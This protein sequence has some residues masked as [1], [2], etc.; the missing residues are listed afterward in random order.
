MEGTRD[1]HGIVFESVCFTYDSADGG[2]E[3]VAGVDL[4]VA[5]GEMTAVVGRNGS[6][7]STLALLANGLLHPSE[8]AVRVDGMYTTEQEHTWDIRSRV[9]IVFQN[10]DNQIVGTIVEE[11]VAFGP[12]NLGVSRPELRFRVDSALEI[13]GLAGMA[14]REP[15]L[16]SGGQK[17]RLAIAGVLAL[18]P[19]YIVFDEPTAML[20]PAGRSDVLALMERLRRDGHG[21]IHITHHLSDV[22]TADRVVVL[23]QGRIVHAG[24]PADL[25]GQADRLGEWGLELPP[26]R[27]MVAELGRLGVNVPADADEPT[28]I[29]SSLWP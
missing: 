2:I 11:D 29:A 15:H 21:I 9:G 16:L 18:N 13:V 3:A 12:E 27:R 14:R 6:G 20:D 26:I 10:P 17:Q 22:S 1:T 7:K 19:A 28:Y 24:S 23:S 4:A 8:G 5:P 25:L